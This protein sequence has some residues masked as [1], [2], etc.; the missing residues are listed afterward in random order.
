VVEEGTHDALMEKEGAYF[1]LYQAQAR[2]MDVDM[3]DDKTVDL[4][5]DKEKTQ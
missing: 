3:D 4:N 2:N 5:S 1:N